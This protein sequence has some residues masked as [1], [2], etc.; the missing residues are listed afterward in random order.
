MRESAVE[1]SYR[2]CDSASALRTSSATIF[3]KWVIPSKRLQK[4][5]GEREGWWLWGRGTK[6]SVGF[7]C[8]FARWC[9]FPQNVGKRLLR[10]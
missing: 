9:G 6:K 7:A 8:I 10:A 1:R 2:R 5:E 4:R 3:L